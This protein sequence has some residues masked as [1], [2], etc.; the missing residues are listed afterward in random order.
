M[1][2]TSFQISWALFWNHPKRLKTARWW[3]QWFFSL[4]LHKFDEGIPPWCAGSPPEIYPVHIAARDGNHKLLR[5]L[6]RAGADPQQKTS[7]GGTC[8]LYQQ[9]SRWMV[10]KPGKLTA[11]KPKVMEDR[12]QMIFLFQLGVCFRFQPLI[13]GILILSTWL[14]S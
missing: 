5:L 8:L 13:F 9:K 3:F 11:K 7:K 10:K 14:G 6:L 4:T 1:T 2:T 12:V